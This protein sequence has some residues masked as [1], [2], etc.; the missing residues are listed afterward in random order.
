MP[1]KTK[2]TKEKPQET[3][4]L[5]DVDLVAK[6]ADK[7]L[8]LLSVDASAK[9]SLDEENNS[10][11]VNIETNESAGL[12]IGNKGENLNAFQSLL[13]MMTKQKEDRWIR[14]SVNIGDWRERQ[15][16]YLKDLAIQVTD[17][18]KETGEP[19]TLYNLSGAQRRIVHMELSEDPG[20]TT[21][22]FG[23]KGERYLVVK[24][25]K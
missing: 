8:E 20:V 11:T 14:I 25:S 2:K 4:T 1:K 10:I 24:P 5:K 15:E 6:F 23:E 7:L 12:L 18:A 19:Q 21:E 17:R 22:S 9:V 16:N 3:V 13:G